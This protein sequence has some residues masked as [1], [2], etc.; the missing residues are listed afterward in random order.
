MLGLRV[1]RRVT[2]VAAALT[3]SMIVASLTATP[4]SAI[5]DPTDSPDRTQLSAPARTWPIPTVR[6]VEVE[7]VAR[8]I[9]LKVTVESSPQLAKARSA[10]IE[11]QGG[12][13]SC[14]IFKTGGLADCTILVGE[15]TSSVSVRARVRIDGIWQRWSKPRTFAVV[16]PTPE[17]APEPEQTGFLA[18]VI[19][20]PPTSCESQA[21]PG[22]PRI[23]IEVTG[24]SIVPTVL[25]QL[26]T[27]LEVLTGTYTVKPLPFDCEGIRYEPREQSVTVT[28]E[29]VITAYAFLY[30]RAVVDPSPPGPGTTASSIL[31]T[32]AVG[33]ETRS[34]YDRDL[35]RHWT[36]ADGD[37]C[38]TREEVLLQ[39]SITPALTEPGCRLTNGRWVSLFDRVETEDPSTFD[40]DH[41]VPLAEAW[42]SGA[43]HW[44]ASTREAFANDLGYAGSLI[45]V[46][47][48]SNRSKGDRDPAEWLPTN[49]SYHCTYVTTWI[50][51]K[52][53]WSLSVDPAE[54]SSLQRHVVACGDPG[55][56]LPPKA[57]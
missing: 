16:L 45:A 11:V 41:M 20:G 44:S 14:L 38:D 57:I 13:K 15:G 55:M 2:A 12:G 37:G 19:A 35:F 10:V 46:S 6:S 36:D 25:T 31:A 50:A 30:F 8:S 39:E 33:T 5:S 56:S 26:A 23:P 17:P 21:R 1:T 22:E 18:L 40:V 3:V 54:K 4:S 42:D 28:V 29:R 49:T 52:Y 51:I 34:G 9:L 53:R 47:A 24:P 7:S 43:N 48:S 32:L 27:R